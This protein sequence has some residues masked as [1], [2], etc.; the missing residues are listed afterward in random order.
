MSSNRENFEVVDE[1]GKYLMSEEHP[2]YAFSERSYS[3]D[4]PVRAKILA[5][6]QATNEFQEIVSGKK[7]V[8]AW[9]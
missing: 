4:R 7:K 5:E 1:T 9:M 3:Q 6:N 8:M 2:E